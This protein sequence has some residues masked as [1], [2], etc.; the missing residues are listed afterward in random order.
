MEQGRLMKLKKIHKG[1]K[2]HFQTNTCPFNQVAPGLQIG[3][4][5][6][7]PIRLVKIGEISA[8]SVTEDMMELEHS[9]TAHGNAK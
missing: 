6:Y 5:H 1:Y 7:T 9:Y 2:I 8:L 3:L 4:H